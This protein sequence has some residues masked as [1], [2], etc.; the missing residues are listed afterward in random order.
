MSGQ[1][2]PLRVRPPM[3]AERLAARARIAAIWRITTGQ[4]ENVDLLGSDD[5][6]A[7]YEALLAASPR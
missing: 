3:T 1:F 7:F 4:D 2:S 6:W 5:Q